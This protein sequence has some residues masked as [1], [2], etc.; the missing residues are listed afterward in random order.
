M[1]DLPVNFWCKGKVIGSQR[2][3]IGHR[4]VGR[5]TIPDAVQLDCVKASSI[6][7]EE[8][9]L[10]ESCWI[11]PAWPLPGFI[12]IT[13]KPD[14]RMCHVSRHLRSHCTG[15]T[16]LLLTGR[17]PSSSWREPQYC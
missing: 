5:E 9:R 6:V 13:R 12:G 7:T 11:E 14:M 16:A 15:S 17:C 3:P 1:G 8:V 2:N 10:F 4:S